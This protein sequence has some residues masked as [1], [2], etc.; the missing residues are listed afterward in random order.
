MHIRLTMAAA[1]LSNRAGTGGAMSL[2]RQSLSFLRS[3]STAAA[4]PASGAAALKK[5]K[6]KKKKNLF[7]LAQFLPNWGI[8][9]HMA[10]T[11][12]TGVS[13]QIT[14]INLYKV[15]PLSFPLPPL[16]SSLPPLSLNFISL[17]D[18]DRVLK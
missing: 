17:S 15:S 1:A 6:R 11:H 14:K 7:E 4:S 8:G 18:V 10:K 13:Y 9:Y 2:F 3:L 12:W 5:P 16:S